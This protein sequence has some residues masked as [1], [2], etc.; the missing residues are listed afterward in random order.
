MILTAEL[1]ISH[2][3]KMKR[4]KVFGMASDFYIFLLKV[5]KHDFI[6]KKYFV[7]Y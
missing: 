4:L 1:P 6:F 5:E 7:H 3:R 2:V